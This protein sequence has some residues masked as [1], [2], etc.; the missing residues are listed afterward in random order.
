MP[1][2]PDTRRRAI[3]AIASGENI[4]VSIN[5]ETV[6]V[7][8][9]AKKDHGV[10]EDAHQKILAAVDVLPEKDGRSDDIA[11]QEIV[12]AVDRAAESIKSMQPMLVGARES[13]DQL[14]AR[15]AALIEKLGRP[16]RKIVDEQ[17]R[18]IGAQRD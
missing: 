2:L 11:H 4:T 17:G 1:T 9:P 13:Q 14:T 12:A 7:Q 6:D 18:L 8:A 3:A 5:G 16:V 10:N 15:I